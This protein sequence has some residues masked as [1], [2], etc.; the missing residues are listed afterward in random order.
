MISTKHAGF[1]INLGKA[2]A[3]DYKLLVDYIKN[4]IYLNRKI[5]LDTEV[6]FVDY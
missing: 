4:E 5:K 6:E 1:I 2:T 3:S